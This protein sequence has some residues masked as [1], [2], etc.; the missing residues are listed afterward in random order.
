MHCPFEEVK[1][2]NRL[3]TF[4]FLALFVILAL[5]TG[6]SVEPVEIRAFPGAEG[7]GAWSQGGR[8]GEVIYV[9]NL[10]DY[11][12]GEK[13]IPGSLRYA[14]C[15]KSPR[16]V[17]FRISGIINLKD[18]LKITNPSIT[19]AGQTAPGDGI[20]LKTH[21][22]R[23]RTHDV[24]IRYIRVRPGDTYGKHG[25]PGWSTDAISVSSPSSN[26]IIDHCST[27]WANDEVLSVSGEKTD[28]VSIQWCIISESLNHSTH[29]KGEHGYASLLRTGGSV[30]YHHNILADHL[31]RTPR[32]G[33]YGNRAG[34]VDFYSNLVYNTVR[35][36]YTARDSSLLNYVGNY[37]KQGPDSQK[38]FAFETGGNT[39]EIYAAG[40]HLYNIHNELISS[41]Q[42]Q[43]I[44]IL[45]GARML[46]KPLPGP[47]METEAPDRLYDTLPEAC[48]AVLPARDPVDTRIT[49]QI[50][51]GKGGIIDS[52]ES[53]NGWPDYKSIAPP[54]DTDLDGMPDAWESDHGLNPDYP[55]DYKL[56]TLDR[57]YNN[58]EVY[59]N[60]IKQTT[61]L[62]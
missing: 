35:S 22:L 27:S 24:I 37:I 26:V 58:L 14:V 7:F 30:S 8:D 15:Q 55:G 46:D 39:T 45:D 34:R 25:H 16:Y 40:N 17:L 61:K 56:K 44:R 53:V 10:E 49:R 33:T 41:D 54:V 9:T 11:A 2:M 42:D 29:A 19:I 38:D 12:H 6:F 50:R 60:S 21:G 13:P 28:S 4:Y 3:T 5:A 51:E 57:N 59:L 43:I 62:K 52:Q 20:C 23:I 31:S 32:T 48:G 18:E 47:P 36:G 1:N